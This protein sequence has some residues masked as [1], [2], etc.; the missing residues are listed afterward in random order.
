MAD[1]CCNEP[2]TTVC[3]EEWPRATAPVNDLWMTSEVSPTSVADYD[4]AARDARGEGGESDAQSAVAQSARI[5][6]FLALLICTTSCCPTLLPWWPV[7][8]A[9]CCIHWLLFLETP[10]MNTVALVRGFVK[11]GWLAMML[12]RVAVHGEPLPLLD[13]SLRWLFGCVLDQL[14][15]AHDTDDVDDAGDADDATRPG[16]PTMQQ[17]RVR[18]RG[19]AGGVGEAGY[20]YGTGR[21]TAPARQSNRS[22]GALGAR[23][24]RGARGIWAFIPPPPPCIGCRGFAGGAGGVW[25]WHAALQCALNLDVLS[26]ALSRAATRGGAQQVG[27]HCAV[28]VYANR[29]AVLNVLAMCLLTSALLHTGPVGKYGAAVRLLSLQR[30]LR[31]LLAIFAVLVGVTSFTWFLIPDIMDGRE[32]G[33]LSLVLVTAFVTALFGSH[34]AWGLSSA[35]VAT[36]RGAAR[37]NAESIRQRK[38]KEREARYEPRHGNDDGPDR[39]FPSLHELSRSPPRTPAYASALRQRGE[40]ESE[41]RRKVE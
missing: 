11:G 16:T 7:I 31:F 12:V 40:W 18:Q 34:S 17:P 26:C 24:A 2:E 15:G 38:A 1:A 20:A 22:R 14:A 27:Q 19:G 8:L 30:R 28:P 5:I 32:P 3:G 33:G 41:R 37:A 21:G 4:P 10:E 39:H 25:I 36:S 9:S 6:S 29:V 23:G 35:E 13:G